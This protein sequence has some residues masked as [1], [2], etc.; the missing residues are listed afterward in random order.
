[1]PAL[2]G[3]ATFVKLNVFAPARFVVE[4]RFEGARES[5]YSLTVPAIWSKPPNLSVT[6]L[7]DAVAARLRVIELAP[8]AVM[9][10]PGWMPAPETA[11]PTTSE[12]V[13]ARLVTDVLEF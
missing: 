4:R 2:A 11:M 13:F 12:L 10:V 1:M 9:V 7:A 5:M 8:T 3:S 6:L